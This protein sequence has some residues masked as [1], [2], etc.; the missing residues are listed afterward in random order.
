MGRCVGKGKR[1]PE[2]VGHSQQTCGKEGVEGVEVYQR[3]CAALGHGDWL[4]PELSMRG[5]PWEGDWADGV[6]GRV[7]CQGS[8]GALI[9]HCLGAVLTCLCFGCAGRGQSLSFRGRS[10]DGREG[11]GKEGRREGGGIRHPPG[12]VG[13]IGQAPAHSRTRALEM[14]ILSLRGTQTTRSLLT[15]PIAHFFPSSIAGYGSAS[16]LQDSGDLW[17]N[18][19]AS[20]ASVIAHPRTLMH[21]VPAD[22]MTYVF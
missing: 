6:S 11:E 9:R 4:Y 2:A 16:S 5:E 15:C 14:H 12:S 17:L 10:E 19:T 20:L 1:A 13:A 22:C 18:L 7:G 8:L 21:A 3:E